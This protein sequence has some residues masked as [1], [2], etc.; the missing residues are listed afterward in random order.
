[1]ESKHILWANIHMKQQYADKEVLN[2]WLCHVDL[3]SEVKKFMI[4]VQDQVLASRNYRKVN[5]K[6]VGI[7]DRLAKF[8]Q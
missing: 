4:V 8:M 6:N 3:L 5:L 1:M 7:I 2:E